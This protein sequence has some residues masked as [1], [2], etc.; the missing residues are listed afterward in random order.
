MSSPCSLSF[1]FSLANALQCR[2]QV[3]Q[4]LEVAVDRGETD[5]SDLVKS[6]QLLHNQ[7]ADLTGR[8][9]GRAATKERG[10]DLV[11]Q[12]LNRSGRDGS[13]MTRRGHATQQFVAAVFLPAP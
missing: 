12:R 8:D 7:L 1:H 5:I 3:F 10:L 13:A 11:H 2:A 9:L 6:A 4:R